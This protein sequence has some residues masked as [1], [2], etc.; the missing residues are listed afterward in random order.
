MDGILNGLQALWDWFIGMGATLVMPVMVL[1][2]GTIFGVKVSKSLASGIKI[3]VGFTA[4]Y[5]MQGA[6]FDVLEGVVEALQSQLHLSL[7]VVDI[8]W[9]TFGAI[10]WGIPYATLLVIGFFLLNWVLIR[11]NVVK[12]LNVDFNNYWI[13][14]LY[15]F[16]I[17]VTTGSFALGLV[18]GVIFWF[19]CTKMSDWIAPWIGPYYQMPTSGLTISHFYSIMWAPL[20]FIMDKIWDRVP[21]INKIKWDPNTIKRKFGFF[22]ENL[23]VGFVVGLLIGIMAYVRFPLRLEA[24]GAALTLGFTTSFFLHLVPRAV[25][26][27]IGGLGPLSEA[28]RKFV[29]KKMPGKEFYVGLDVAVCVGASENGAVGVLA[30][31]IALIMAFIL[32]FNRVI[33]MGNL[34]TFIYSLTFLICTNKGNIFRGLLNGMLLYMPLA[35]YISGAM[36]PINT[37]MMEHLGGSFPVPEGLAL[38]TT[39][40]LGG[41]PMMFAFMLICQFIAGVGSSSDLI[42]A[43]V[44]LAIFYG[45]WYLMRNR[46]KEFYKEIVEANESGEREVV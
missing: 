2:L 7:D 45:S 31:P 43:I 41:V 18:A 12:T 37:L 26:L 35:L 21:V 27:I 36:A 40:S 38:V 10:G 46:S 28:I 14:T 1:A 3:A 8:G 39:I 34:T 20:G 9:V 11:F 17:E 22:G 42:F 33:P 44:V 19:S 4:L 32:P 13:I 29:T 5:A 6:V 23:F 25:E 30:A 24:I 16:A 15:V